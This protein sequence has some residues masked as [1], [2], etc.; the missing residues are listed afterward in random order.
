MK[1]LSIRH[2]D[3]TAHP[4]PHTRTA[5]G[6]PQQ[7]TRSCRWSSQNSTRH[8]REIHHLLDGAF[9]EDFDCFLQRTDDLVIIGRFSSLLPDFRDFLCDRTLLS[10]CCNAFSARTN[11]SPLSPT[12]QFNTNFSTL[13]TRIGPSDASF[14]IARTIEPLPIG[15]QTF[16]LAC[17]ELCSFLSQVLGSRPW[18]FFFMGTWFPSLAVFS[19]FTSIWHVFH[20]TFCSPWLGAGTCFIVASG[21]PFAHLQEDSFSVCPA[22]VAGCDLCFVLQTR[23]CRMLRLHRCKPPVLTPTAIFDELLLVTVLMTPR[24]TSHPPWHRR[25]GFPVSLPASPLRRRFTRALVRNV[26]SHVPLF[27]WPCHQSS[28]AAP[29]LCASPAFTLPLRNSGRCT[30]F[31]VPPHLQ[32]LC[33]VSSPLSSLS[34]VCQSS[35]TTLRAG[36]PQ[37]ALPRATGGQLVLQRCYHPLRALRVGSLNSCHQFSL[38]KPHTSASVGKTESNCMNNNNDNLSESCSVSVSGTLCHRVVRWV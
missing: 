20:Q 25:H 10:A 34:R 21:E 7:S 14:P 32:V 19:F 36:S 35:S 24:A 6:V 38:G 5:T 16:P 12:L 33:V 37:H 23:A 28:L 3:S 29:P 27:G 11:L 17:S 13:I 15:T 8:I 1:T 9:P 22:L 31:H 18:L 4:P 26:S 30:F 2:C